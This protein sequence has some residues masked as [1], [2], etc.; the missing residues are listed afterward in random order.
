[1]N[2][3]RLFISYS[4]SNP[5]HEQWVVDLANDL[6][7]S[8]I[9]V[10]LDKWDLR[11]GHDAI[12]FMEKMVTDPS[13]AKVAL[14]CDEGYATKADGRAGGVGTETQIIS[15]EV[16][17][18]QDQGKFVAVIAEKGTD[19]KP[20][21]PTYYKSRIYIDLSESERYAE[22]F[23]KLV[24]WV[25]DKPLFKRP[26][27]GKPP[28]F[29]TDSTAPVLGTAPLAKRVVDA[30]RGD[31]AYARGAVDEYF[32]MFAEQLERFRIVASD[33][34]FDERVAKSIEDFLPARNE[35]LQVLTTLAQY[36][37]TESYASRLHRFYESLIPYLDRPPHINQWN[38]LDFDNFKFIVHELFLYSVAVLLKGE[39]FAITDY[40]LGQPYYVPGNS[41]HGKN[42]TVSFT[43]LQEHV[44]SLDIRNQRLKLN[45]ASLRADLLEQRSHASGLAFRHLMQADFVCFLRGDVM[46]GDGWYRW[47]P[48]TLVY[49]GRQHGPFEIFAR[50]SSKAYLPSVLKVVGVA[51]VSAL[52]E[53]LDSYATDRSFPRWSYRSFSPTVLTGIELLGTRS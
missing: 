48:D 45:R 35:F 47:W 5:Q 28:S 41:D 31:K 9:D 40:L 32:T 37:E 12:A 8:G 11:E 52:K 18:K 13:I 1:V 4:W 51:E 38:E 42:A 53:R 6:V 49:A 22:N 15:A 25:F 24:R 33:G 39:H 44:K 17:V 2:T 23:E 26:E 21:L 50:A 16:Y 19:G 43:A 30:L 34:E 36:A 46:G 14:V 20:F 29:I 7:A 3:P 10:V 27:L